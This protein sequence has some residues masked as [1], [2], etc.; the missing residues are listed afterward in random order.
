MHTLRHCFC[1]A[2][3][4]TEGRHPRHPGAPRTQE[5][6]DHCAVHSGGHRDS[7]PS[8]LSPRDHPTRVGHPRAG[9]RGDLPRPRSELSAATTRALE[10]GPAQ[11]HVRRRA[12]SQRRSG[13]ACAAL[14][15]L[16]AAPDRLQL[17]SQPPLRQMPGQCRATLASRGG[18]FTPAFASARQRP[19]SRYTIEFW[20]SLG[21]S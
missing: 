2:P 18:Q 1:H 8:D 10:P 16:R 14:L 6:R 19:M 4:R 11:G 3:A 17:L 5:A 7:A 12:L 21:T 15:G 13:R 20:G 9:G